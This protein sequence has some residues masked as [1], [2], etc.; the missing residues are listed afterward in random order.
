M[1]QSCHIPFAN[2]LN[3]ISERLCL[4][5]VSD[6]DHR[7]GIASAPYRDGWHGGLRDYRASGLMTV[8]FPSSVRSSLSCES[9]LLARSIASSVLSIQPDPMSSPI[10]TLPDAISSSSCSIL[11]CSCLHQ[12]TKRSVAAAM[13]RELYGASARSIFCFASATALSLYGAKVRSVDREMSGKSARAALMLAHNS[14]IGAWGR[15]HIPDSSMCVLLSSKSSSDG[16]PK[17]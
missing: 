6:G 11:A 14:P 1:M 3:Q 15:S 7:T 10:L 5:R 9:R 2:R 17:N 4:G 12:A 8:V 16:R 13:V